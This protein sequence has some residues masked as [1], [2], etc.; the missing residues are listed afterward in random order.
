MTP[1]ILTFCCSTG[2]V[3]SGL[4]RDWVDKRGRSRRWTLGTDVQR[5]WEAEQSPKSSL[6]PGGP[7]SLIQVPSQGP[8][9]GRVTNCPEM[10]GGAQDRQ[11]WEPA[12]SQSGRSIQ[13]FTDRCDDGC[14]FCV[15]AFLGLQRLPSIPSP[16]RV[17]SPLFSGLGGADRVFLLCV[18]NGVSLWDCSRDTWN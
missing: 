2:L 5:G 14:R 13:P 18:P 1:A 17:L 7:E 8:R 15:D 11:D 4:E 16:R 3:T 6:C 10:P 9:P 12:A